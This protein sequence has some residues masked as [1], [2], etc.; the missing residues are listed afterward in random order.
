LCLLVCLAVGVSD[1]SHTS[2][3]H[4]QPRARHTSSRFTH[5]THVTRHT[6]SH[7]KGAAHHGVG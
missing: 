3:N 6:S 5:V 2:H 1:A 7:T 4:T